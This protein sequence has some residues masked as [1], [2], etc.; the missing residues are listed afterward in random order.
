MIKKT[1]PQNNLKPQISYKKNGTKCDFFD[2]I[3]EIKRN[4]VAE[5]YLIEVKSS[6]VPNNYCYN[7]ELSEY[8]KKDVIKKLE[9]SLNKIPDIENS[10]ELSF[11]KG[12]KRF[13]KGY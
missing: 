5:Y 13:C 9:K 2:W 8:Y 10:I 4:D 12:K 6:E 11:L 1:L 3:L 7:E